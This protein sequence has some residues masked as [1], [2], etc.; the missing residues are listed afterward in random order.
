MPSLDELES[1]IAHL[2]VPYKGLTV[3]IDYYPDR[4]SMN[5]QRAIA[6]LSRP[7]HDVGPITEELALVLADWDLTR[8]GEPVPITP[9]GVGS[10]GIALSSAIGGSIMEDFNDPKSPRSTGSTSA[11][12]TDSPPGSK[13]DASAG[14]PTGPISSS[15]RSGRDST[16]RTSPDSPTLAAV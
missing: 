1:G 16:R 5:M 9:D 4:V 11:S 12:L 6:V 7:P 10:L 13:P 8:G 15:A 2:S 14:V 3:E